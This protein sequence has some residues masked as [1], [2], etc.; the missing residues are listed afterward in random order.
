[1]KI[2]AAG[3]ESIAGSLPFTGADW[4]NYA[5]YEFGVLHV[6]AG[7]TALSIESADPRSG[8]Y[9]MN[10]RSVIL[11][12][13][14]VLLTITGDKVNLRAKPRDGAILSQSD[15]G[16]QFIAESAQAADN[17]D[18]SKWYRIAASVKNGEVAPF[19]AYVSAKYASAEKPPKAL[20]AKIKGLAAAPGS[21]AQGFRPVLCDG[22]F[23]GAFDE[24]GAWHGSP[25]T[26]TVDGKT[27]KLAEIEEDKN[28]MKRL[29]GGDELKT[30]PCETPLIKAGQKLA[31]WGTDGKKGEGV[32]SGTAI[33][34]EGEESGAAALV[35]SLDGFEWDGWLTVGVTEGINA[36]PAKTVREETGGNVIFTCDYGGEKLSVAWKE[37]APDPREGTHFKGFVSAGK[38]TWEISDDP[39]DE[40]VDPYNAEDIHCGFFDLDGDKK[41][42]LVVYD[43]GPNGSLAIC[44]TD[45]TKIAW[46]YTGNE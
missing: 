25:G 6:P 17:S 9:V 41:L 3:G 4:S 5:E 1:V 22:T 38:H 37:T 46:M 40:S 27:V 28:L 10:L 11:T 19:S 8:K 13:E 45:G 44:R 43:S 32:V 21:P 16:G 35:V 42:E 34:Y 12:P 36:L 18:G 20:A 7:H 31:C 2:T 24:N 15:K 23:I 30:V 33:Y 29:T 26:V 39:Y 14:Y